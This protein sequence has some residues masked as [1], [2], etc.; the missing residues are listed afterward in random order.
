MYT[1]QLTNRF[2]S[3]C[4]SVFLS[5]GPF[6]SHSFV[7]C[8]QWNIFECGDYA[9]SILSFSL[10]SILSRQEYFTNIR[11]SAVIWMLV[12]F[13]PTLLTN[14][15]PIFCFFI[16]NC[17]LDICWNLN[18]AFPQLSHFLLTQTGFYHHLYF[19]YS[20]RT[21]ALMTV[22]KHLVIKSCPFNLHNVFNPF[23]LFGPSCRTN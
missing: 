19:S 21:P 2:C 16:F 17:R 5:Y 6:P 13:Q 3:W 8:C 11:A 9:L 20:L 18:P 23:P 22:L 15:F 4:S 7:W 14:T 10:I 12:I 1:E